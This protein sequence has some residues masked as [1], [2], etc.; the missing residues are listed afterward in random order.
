MSEDALNLS[1]PLQH[2]EPKT[3][4]GPPADGA[5]VVYH[6]APGPLP[7]ATGTFESDGGAL[8]ITCSGSGSA[9]QAPDTI[10]MG[11]SIDNRFAGMAYAR[12]ANTSTHFF[13]NTFA[14]GPLKAGSHTMYV[15]PLGNTQTSQDDVFNVS[16][17]SQ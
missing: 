5:T 11:I 15:F 1:L 2:L 12:V 13:S 3:H 16:F 6:D 10:G 8:I 14:F 4:A 7:L 17:T 9:P